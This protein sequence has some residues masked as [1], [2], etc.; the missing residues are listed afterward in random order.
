[1]KM[2][3]I[4]RLSNSLRIS[5]HYFDLLDSTNLYLKRLLLDSLEIPALVIARSQ[6]NGQGRLGKHFYSPEQTG[7][8]ITFS[9]HEND[10]RVPDLTPRVALAVARSIDSVFGTSTQLKWVNDIYL[11]NRKIS[12][13][14]CQKIGD[15]FLIGIGVNIQKPSHIPDEIKDRFGYL[16][17]D[18]EI[19]CYERLIVSIQRHL[20]NV[21]LE[22]HEQVLA[23]YRS[24]CIHINKRITIEVDS[25]PFEGT[26]VGIGDDFSLVVES[27][28]Q[29][30]YFTSGYMTI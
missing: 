4:K 1:M 23:E 21:F 13:I 28:N 3:D 12:G 20:M 7:L 15:Q 18:C 25:K 27:N 26:C 5:I 6:T 10:V 17:E 11:R 14:L 19:D 30:H 9:F 24:R 16:T 8:Y 2:L 22:A 29:L